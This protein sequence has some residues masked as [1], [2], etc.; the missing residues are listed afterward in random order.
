MDSVTLRQSHFKLGDDINKY[1]TSSMEQSEGI[2]NHKQANAV[3]DQKARNELR[4]SH[5]IFGNFE[6]NY[7]TTFR[8]EYYNKSSS[9]PKNKVD[10]ANIERKLRTQNFQFGTDKPDYLSET[11]AKYIIPNINKEDN[12]QNKI[13]T[14]MLQ[15]SHYVFGNSQVPWNT[16]N[17]REFTPKKADTT[18]GTKDLTKTNFILG[19]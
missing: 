9:L 14:A 18:R 5:F 1:V 17:R 12:K 6:P 13:S 10:F 8:R 19:K 4:K 2:E 16:T 3:L 11:A 15:Q 7:N